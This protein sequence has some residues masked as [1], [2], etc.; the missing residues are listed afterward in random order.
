MSSGV[1]VQGSMA[2]E[3]R[4]ATLVSEGGVWVS[5]V[6]VCFGVVDVVSAAGTV[7]VGEDVG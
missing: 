3:E 5:V 2:A 7:V 6:R 4:A 1:W